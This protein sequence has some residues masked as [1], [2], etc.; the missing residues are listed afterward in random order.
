M[1]PTKTAGKISSK[2]AVFTAPPGWHALWS[3]STRGWQ[4]ERLDGTTRVIKEFALPTDRNPQRDAWKRL[5][6][7]I[8]NPPAL[9]DLERRM[10]AG[11]FDMD[12]D[13]DKSRLDFCSVKKP[14]RIVRLGGDEWIN[15]R[16][17][18]GFASDL[19]EI[20]QDI[21]PKAKLEATKRKA[22]AAQSSKAKA[23]P[24]SKRG[25]KVG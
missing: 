4:S 8:A 23:T 1:T 12:I 24:K 17:N 2:T 16:G 5:L 6:H 15:V 14:H 21:E 19:P 11:Y 13:A 25:P 18:A 3:D 20:P 10:R 7:R 9:G 22:T